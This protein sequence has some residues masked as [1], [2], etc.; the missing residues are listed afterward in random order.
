V[1]E[2][3][4]VAAEASSGLFAQ[5]L[6]E[7]WK[8][9]K[10]QVK[11]FGVGNVEMERLGFERLGQS[12]EMAVVGISEVI[13]HYADIKAVFENILEQCR[14]RKP[15]VAV[16]MDYPGFNL[17]LA[18]KLHEM[19]IPVVYYISPQIWAWH[20]SRV[21]KVKAYCA[22]MLVLFPFEVKFY[23]G[24]GV[25]VEFVGHPLLDEMDPKYFDP[26]HR[27]WHRNR[28]GIQDDETVIGL[29]PGSRRGEIKQHL[30]L[31]LDVARKLHKNFNKIRILLLVAPTREKEEIQDQL[32]D[33]HFPLMMLKDE[34]LEMIEL[35]D[36]M[37]AASGTAT[38]QV[39]LMEKP[40]V[41]MYKMK[42]ITEWLARILVR[43][44]KFF[45]LPN[46]VLGREVVPERWKNDVTVDGLYDLMKRYLTDPELIAKTKADLATIRTQLGDKGATRRVAQ[47]LEGYLQ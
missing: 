10:K 12:E 32:G 44:V 38:L 39:A 22:K 14:V 2:V 15:K 19:G 4:V 33:L 20:K 46:L 27:K 5:R 35:C 18:Q 25:P 3:L 13:E 31:Q 41:I 6:L 45:G 34:P 24:H 47:A 28:C 23:E 40:M 21:K 30:Q 9:Q 36:L 37:L 8:A 26:V 1:N 11:T 29:M 17:R 16:L 7:F 42:P 43:G